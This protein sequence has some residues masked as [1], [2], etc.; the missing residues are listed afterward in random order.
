MLVNYDEKCLG[1]LL[2]AA[3]GDAYGWPYE[4]NS[5]NTNVTEKKSID[6]IEWRHRAGGRFWAH[7]ERILPGEYSDDT[8][9]IIATLRAL[10]EGKQWSQHFIAYELPAWLSYARGAGKAT[11]KAAELWKKGKTPWEL[12]KNPYDVVNK[13]FMAGG[14]GA[15]MRVLPHAFLSNLDNEEFMEQVFI[16]S[17]YTHGHPRAIMGAMLYATAVKYILQ[18]ETTL[19]YGELVEYLLSDQSKWT[20]IPK[21]SKIENWINKAEE[22]DIPYYRLWEDA[23]YETNDLLHI[24]KHSLYNGSLDLTNETLQE[25]G[26]FDKKINGAGNRT[27]IISIYLFS[28]YADSPIECI[29]KAGTL[30]KADTDTIASMAGG[31][32][33]ALHGIDW[34]PDEWKSVQD[35]EMFRTLVILLLTKIDSSDVVPISNFDSDTIFTRTNIENMKPGE[36][37]Q[38]KPFGRTYLIEYREEKSL[39][40]NNVV[41]TAV[42]KTEY[43]QTLYVKK[44]GKNAN[45]VQERYEYK[46]YNLKYGLLKL[47]VKIIGDE[48][49]ANDYLI[50]INDIVYQINNNIVDRAFAEGYCKKWEQ[51]NLTMNQIKRVADLLKKEIE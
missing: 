23:A 42:M 29:K 37:K 17:M 11:K 4:Q 35:Y 19:S 46:D 50:F 43:G 16:N 8:Q 26:C 20:K 31:L 38:F 34:I 7:E 30:K 6:F 21:N 44:M 47:I 2:G 45:S 1:A 36:S 49:K 39:L 41:N 27:A 12:R 22:N 5:K 15:A 28:K 9:L 48:W 32:L 14:N 51:Y 3:I 18:C 24:V 33:G 40:P 25:L 13:Y 10:L